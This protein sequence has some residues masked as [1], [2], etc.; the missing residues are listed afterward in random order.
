MSGLRII[1]VEQGTDEWLEARRGM[2]TASTVGQLVTPRTIQPAA[3]VF[4]TLV[5]RC[6]VGCAVAWTLSV[7]GR[8]A[9]PSSVGSGHSNPRTRWKAFAKQTRTCRTFLS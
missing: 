8:I 7:D 2:I 4:A 6:A 3:V 5:R 1:D 9:Y